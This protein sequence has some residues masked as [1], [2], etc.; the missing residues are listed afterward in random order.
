MTKKQNEYL[1]K[2]KNLFG[3]GHYKILYQFSHGHSYYIFVEILSNI[4][5][6]WKTKIYSKDYKLL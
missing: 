1:V 5:G 4:I 2:F 3:D 6:N